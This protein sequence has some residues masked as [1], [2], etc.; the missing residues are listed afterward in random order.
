VFREESL[1][2]SLIG[3]LVDS[4][5]AWEKFERYYMGSL[6]PSIAKMTTTPG[7]SVASTV[8]FAESEADK[9]AREARFLSAATQLRER[10]T[11]DEWRSLASLVHAYRS[12][13]VLKVAAE[14]Q[15][16]QE[17]LRILDS[18][19]LEAKLLWRDRADHALLSEDA[20]SEVVARFVEKWA[21]EELKLQ[22]DLEQAAAVG[23]VGG[24]VQIIARAGAGK[25]RTLVTR[26]I[27]LQKHCRVAPNELL[28][29]AFNRSA[30]EEMR[31]RL[32]EQ[33][34]STIPHVM[35]FHALAHALVHPEEQLL[36]DEPAVG[37]QG[38]SREVQHVIDD[39]LRSETFGPVIRELMLRH[40][41]DDWER[42]VKGGFHLPIEE[43][44]EYRRSLPRET[45]R[46]DYVKSFGEKLIAN[47][48]FEKDVA[49]KYES[50]FRWNGVNYKPD[51]L[52]PLRDGG[53]LV[54]EY[55]GLSGDPDY[56]RMSEEKRAFWREQAE[57]VFLEFAPS[58]IVQGG[59]EKFKDVLLER[60]RAAGVAT[61]QLDDEAIWERIQRRAI[62]QFTGAAKSF[63]SRCRK[64]NL[65]P[66]ALD[67]RLAAHDPISDTERLFLQ[68][69]TSI[70]RGYLRQL[71]DREHEDFD[72]LIWRAV[73][74]LNT[75]ESDFTRD[76][77]RQRGDVR[78]LR[79]VLVD[80]FQDFSEM[81][82]ALASAIRSVNSSAKF[83]CVGDDWQAIN[84][85]A[86]SD[87]KFFTDFQRYFRD[88]T[89]LDVRT[90]YRSRRHVVEVGNALMAGRGV[91]AVAD[92]QDPG[93]VRR[94]RLT[95]FE[96][97]PA[98]R[99]RHDGDE[100]TPALLR[101]IKHLFDSGRDVVMLARTNRVPWYVRYRPDAHSKNDGLERFAEHLRSFFPDEDQSRLK[102]STTHK[103]KG[104]ESPAVVILDADSYPLIHPNWIF[105][106]A[107]GDRVAGIEDE[108]RRLFYV[109]LT[110]SEHS[111][112]ILSEGS[113]RES[114]Y[115]KEIRERTTTEAVVW[116]EFS[117][118]P[119]LDAPQLEIRVRAPYDQ[120]LREQLKRRGFKWNPKDRYWWRLL[121][122]GTSDLDEITSQ[123]WATEQ[124]VMEVVTEDGRAWP[125]KAAIT[126]SS[127]Q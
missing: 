85:F 44:V 80:E 112:V 41:R 99:E 52:V 110:R 121:P 51:F 71:E 29:L 10:L 123:P 72:G 14:Q 92:K 37:S 39:H 98:E 58:D 90:N 1:I 87:L 49:Y 8:N 28:L 9:R 3:Q 12:G 32:T 69:I 50:N 96:P 26:A 113:T 36:F 107:L 59:P 106:R 78:N 46:G 122:A 66:G 105:L 33:L 18:N 73:D 77:G 100:A 55:F 20:F 114:P 74:R 35:T 42:I 88:T 13:S 93:W 95:D 91:A 57:Y 75:G 19:F 2:K 65:T 4:L 81:F 23:A 24:D 82:F 22:L 17:A 126:G 34:G 76:G 47:T 127:T 48:L 21:S 67:R 30:A 103:Y 124:V 89:T 101:L 27:F 117:T 25:T 116:S 61:R 31:K 53:K 38:L 5:P 6:L 118:P 60:L 40:F 94:A 68:V 7:R 119:S 115:L 11:T 63:V 102:V 125:H 104:L 109:A 15:A 79:F 120:E 43:L 45:L 111:L 54:I 70:Y 97:S 62:D 84:G 86:G 16:E 56:D 108:E 64:K 83:F